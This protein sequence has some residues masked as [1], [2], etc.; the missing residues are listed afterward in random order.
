MCRVRDLDRVREQSFSCSVGAPASLPYGHA[1]NP[2]ASKQS[3]QSC[4]Q[5][6]IPWTKIRRIHSERLALWEPTDRNSGEICR[7]RL[8]HIRSGARHVERQPAAIF[9]NRTAPARTS[10]RENPAAYRASSRDLRPTGA[11]KTR[12]VASPTGRTSAPSLRGESPARNAPNRKYIT[13]YPPRS[14]RRKPLFSACLIPA[15]MYKTTRPRLECD[16]DGD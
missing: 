4:H 15:R 11:S 12:M 1:M 3:C 16:E 9:E 5:R 2:S 7:R 13:P 6:G 10:S 14:R 8:R